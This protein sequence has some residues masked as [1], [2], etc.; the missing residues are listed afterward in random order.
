VADEMKRRPPPARLKKRGSEGDREYPR[1]RIP[2]SPFTYEGAEQ[3][4]VKLQVFTFGSTGF[5]ARTLRS[6][7]LRAF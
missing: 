2:P 3:V 1:V 5:E 7:Y 6:V 4:K